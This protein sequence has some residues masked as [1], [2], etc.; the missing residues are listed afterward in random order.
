MI[1][2]D[3]ELSE[4][5]H[6]SCGRPDVEWKDCDFWYRHLSDARN[7]AYFLRFQPLE[8]NGGR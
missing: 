1:P 7:V 2:A 4:V 3:D 5:L 8:V 6:R